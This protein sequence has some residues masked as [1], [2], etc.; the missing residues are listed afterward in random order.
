MK[1]KLFKLGDHAGHTTTRKVFFCMLHPTL[2]TLYMLYANQKYIICILHC[3][4]K[5]WSF[6]SVGV[7]IIQVRLIRISVPIC[8][9][10]TL[11][12]VFAD[13]MSLQYLIVKKIVKGVNYIFNRKKVLLMFMWILWL[14]TG[15]VNKN[16]DFAYKVFGEMYNVV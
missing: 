12:C 16:R 2:L 4:C 13:V 9:A 3:V 6:D 14:L 10:R 8:K 15:L 1:K 7:Y 11:I 5:Y